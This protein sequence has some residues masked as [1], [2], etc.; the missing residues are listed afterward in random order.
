MKRLEALMLRSNTADGQRDRTE[1]EASVLGLYIYL[2]MDVHT[3]FT[4]PSS[5]WADA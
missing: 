2:H 4:E 1:A 3:K 5:V